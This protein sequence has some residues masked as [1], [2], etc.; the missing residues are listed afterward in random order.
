MLFVMAN[1]ARH[2]DIDPEEAL[3]MANAKFTRRFQSIEAAL[4]ADGRPPADRDLAEKD[5]QWN[6][7]KV[8]EKTAG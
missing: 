3:R 7:A 4:A 8:A 2:L 6:A 1:L 5:R